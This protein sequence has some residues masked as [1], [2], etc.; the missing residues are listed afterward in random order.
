MITAHSLVVEELKKELDSHLKSSSVANLATKAL[1]GITQLALHVKESRSLIQKEEE[2]LFSALNTGRYQ[3]RFKSEIDTEVHPS[4]LGSYRRGSNHS[5]HKKEGCQQ[6]CSRNPS[7]KRKLEDTASL[8]RT[9][10]S[11]FSQIQQKHKQEAEST[12]KAIN[13]LSR[14]VEKQALEIH[15]LKKENKQLKNLTAQ[16][17]NFSI[18]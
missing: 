3:E 13:D 1:L 7:F 2:N 14:Q 4:N 17:D 9:P 16:R 6:K 11:N 18:E 15:A 12:L 8:Q 10:R 5:S